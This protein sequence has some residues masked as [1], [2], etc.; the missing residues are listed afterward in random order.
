MQLRIKPISE[1]RPAKR[2]SR[3]RNSHL[4]DLWDIGTYDSDIRDHLDSYKEV[5]TG[6]LDLERKKDIMVTVLAT[7]EP[8]RPNPFA[9]DYM[10]AVESLGPIMAAKTVR[11]FHYSRMTDDEVQAVQAEGIVPTSVDSLKQRVDRQ[12]I[13]GTLTREQGDLIID[14]GPLQTAAFGVRHGFWSTS[15][16][17][18]P[19]NAAVNLLVDHWGGESAYWLFTGP[20]DRPMVEVLKRIGRGRVI[21]IAMSLK[22][23]NGGLAGFSAARTAVRGY[24]RSLDHQI[25]PEALDLA[26]EHPLP[27]SHILKV[28]TEGEDGY[29]A[30]G[31]GYPSNY[32]APD[33]E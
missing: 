31:R 33:A 30:M 19:D 20:E 17:I 32:V 29:I 11:A 26:L 18:H 13:S 28:H 25:Y 6:Y 10:S 15:S 2:N 23:P 27:A 5:I 14:R 8:I 21:E 3:S 9:A 16:P 7:W 22:D 1:K 24:V 4:I 12:V